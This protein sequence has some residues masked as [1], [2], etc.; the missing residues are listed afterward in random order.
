MNIFRSTRTAEKKNFVKAEII[1]EKD[2]SLIYQY[3]DDFSEFNEDHSKKAREMEIILGNALAMT[4]SNNGS[5]RSL[6]RS[7]TNSA[8]EIGRRIGSLHSRENLAN[9][10]AH[11]S[12]NDSSSYIS[13]TSSFG[14]AVSL[15]TFVKADKADSMI[16]AQQS[17]ENMMFDHNDKNNDENS[18]QNTGSDHM[19][20]KRTSNNTDIT[21]T[22]APMPNR[23]WSKLRREVNEEA[24]ATTTREKEESPTF[25]R[26]QSIGRIALRFPKK[27]FRVSRKKSSSDTRQNRSSSDRSKED[28]KGRKGY[29]KDYDVEVSLQT[30]KKVWDRHLPIMRGGKGKKT[31]SSTSSKSETHEN[32]NKK[33]IS[34]FRKLKTRK[35]V[36]KTAEIDNSF[37]TPKTDAEDS[38]RAPLESITVERN[39]DVVLKMHET[40][41]GDTLFQALEVACCHSIDAGTLDLITDIIPPQV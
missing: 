5:I 7:G 27:T 29:A 41:K 30:Q 4:E 22:D 19:S 21:T 24:R 10:E 6:Q 38:W 36:D 15:P 12:N 18:C 2:D 25:R 8:I 11:L 9:S 37:D 34:Y 39:S 28:N 32:N 20:H 35:T 40:H 14:S 23:S 33:A 13:R 31:I 3:D 17:L 26:T 16:F 1:A